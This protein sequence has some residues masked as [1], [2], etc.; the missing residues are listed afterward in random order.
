M[1]QDTN[2]KFAYSIAELP[3]LVSL[4][5]S[6]IYEEIRAGKLRTVKAGRRTLVLA[7]DLRAWL[8]SMAEASDRPGPPPQQRRTRV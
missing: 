8:H 3:A 1:L 7:E 4:G 5:R 2:G 6:H